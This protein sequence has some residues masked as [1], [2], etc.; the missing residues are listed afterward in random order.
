M[1]VGADGGSAGGERGGDTGDR[2]EDAFDVHHAPPVIEPA[3][4]HA[5]VSVA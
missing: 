4:G 5:A 2:E 3:T 1:R